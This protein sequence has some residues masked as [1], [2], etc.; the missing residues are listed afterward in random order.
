M[1][2]EFAS[3]AESPRNSADSTSTVIELQ[4]CTAVPS[5]NADSGGWIAGPHAYMANPLPTVLSSRFSVPRSESLVPESLQALMAIDPGSSVHAFLAS[6]HDW[7]Q[8]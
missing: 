2:L 4:A 5:F 1:N 7:Q 6:P 3:S 8:V